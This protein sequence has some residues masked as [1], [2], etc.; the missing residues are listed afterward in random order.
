MSICEKS[1]IKAVCDALMRVDAG[2]LLVVGGREG[3]MCGSP[4]AAKTTD[5]TRT[6]SLLCRTAVL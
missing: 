1:V 5:G 4:A 2:R 3:R 6:E